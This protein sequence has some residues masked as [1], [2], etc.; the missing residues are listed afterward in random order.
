MREK[1]NTKP[2][3]LFLPLDSIGE[4]TAETL[5]LNKYEINVIMKSYLDLWYAE[6]SNTSVPLYSLNIRFEDRFQPIVSI[7]FQNGISYY[8]K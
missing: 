7:F 4:I 8:N 6:Q 5:F 1:G 2:Y 3:E